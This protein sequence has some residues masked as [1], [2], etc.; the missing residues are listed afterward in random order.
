VEMLRQ[1]LAMHR[2][3]IGLLE[4]LLQPGNGL[5]PEKQ[6]EMQEK[7]AVFRCKAEEIETELLTCV[8]EPESDS[9]E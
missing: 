5:T 4:G 6:L 2:S 9:S 7:L 1:S 8:S 3:G